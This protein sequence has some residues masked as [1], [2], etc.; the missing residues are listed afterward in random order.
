MSESS[1]MTDLGPQDPLCHA[2]KGPAFKP[3]TSDIFVY[4]EWPY[5][6]VPLLCW[7]SISA[8]L[9]LYTTK[10]RCEA[11]GKSYLDAVWAAREC[12]QNERIG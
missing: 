12:F 4:G 7:M 1:F 2:P 8:R 11:Q 3:D 10:L 5:L 9:R 6:E